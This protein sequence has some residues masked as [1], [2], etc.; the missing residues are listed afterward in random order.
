MSNLVDARVFIL[1][2][3]PRSNGPLSLDK[4]RLGFVGLSLTYLPKVF[5]VRKPFYFTLI[6]DSSIGRI[7]CTCSYK[8]FD[9]VLV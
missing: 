5:A 7:F 8:F 6:A 3:V 9:L 1:K 4:K 2:G